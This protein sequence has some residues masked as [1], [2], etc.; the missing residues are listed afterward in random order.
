MAVNRS[1]GAKILRDHVGT[2]GIGISVARVIR[3]IF[4]K[5]TQELWSAGVEGRGRIECQLDD[6]L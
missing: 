4:E 1:L 5:I 2:N 3:H 6:E